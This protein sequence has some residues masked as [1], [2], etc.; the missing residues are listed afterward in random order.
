VSGEQIG[1][2][3][4]SSRLLPSLA[5]STRRE[6]SRLNLLFLPAPNFP[7]GRRSSSQLSWIQRL[8][9]R[10]GIGLPVQLNPTG[11]N[12]PIESTAPAPRSI[13]RRSQLASWSGIETNAS[14]LERRA[15]VGA[16]ELLGPGHGGPAA[17]E[18]REEVRVDSLPAQVGIAWD[19]AG[20]R[21]DEVPHPVAKEN[22][23]A[24]LLVFLG[25]RRLSSVGRS[26]HGRRPAD[27]LLSPR[28]DHHQTSDRGETMVKPCGSHRS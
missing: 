15:T 22:A 2:N 1:I 12:L 20:G 9:A 21:N 8:T 16:T 18:H 19:G 4:D 13:K 14:P 3:S 5:V 24:L 23:G 17:S 6:S 27:W 10:G 25:I 28:N 26:D 11:P 7:T